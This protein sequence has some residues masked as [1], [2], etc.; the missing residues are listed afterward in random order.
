MRAVPF[1]GTDSPRPIALELEGLW[2]SPVEARNLARSLY[3]AAEAC[4]G[5]RYT[6]AIPVSR[7]GEAFEAMRPA[8]IPAAETAP[9]IDDSMRLCGVFR[10]PA[11][12]LDPTNASNA[13]IP[14][15]MLDDGRKD[16]LDGRR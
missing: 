8:P 9:E 13:G 5:V 15:R 16:A 10:Q 6:A 4:D 11:C 2:V 3:A 1:P 14:A 7:I 12:L